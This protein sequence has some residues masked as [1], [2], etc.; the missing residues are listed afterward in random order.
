MKVSL[1]SFFAAIYNTSHSTRGDSIIA[2]L[3]VPC[4]PAQRV[5]VYTSIEAHQY[6]SISIL[7]APIVPDPPP[8]PPGDPSLCSFIVIPSIPATPSTACV[9]PS[10]RTPTATT[11][12]VSEVVPDPT[13]PLCVPDHLR[14]ATCC[15]SPSSSSS[16]VQSQFQ[17]TVRSFSSA[18]YIL[19]PIRFHSSHAHLLIP[20]PDPESN[21][22]APADS[23]EDE[24]ARAA[25]EEDAAAAAVEED[26]EEEEDEDGGDALDEDADAARYDPES[27]RH[28]L[29]VLPPSNDDAHVG[30]AFKSG[31]ST[32]PKTSSALLTLGDSVKTVIAFSN[33]A[34][35]PILV[36]G[37]IGS[38]NNPDNFRI[39]VQN[40]TYGLVNR[41]VEPGHELSFSYSF[42]PNAHLDVRPFQLAITLFYE[43]QSSMGAAL[44]GHSTTFYNATVETQPGS[45]T[46]SNTTFLL[47]FVTLVAAAGGAA[48]IFKN[49][50]GE[51]NE[52]V[53]T[54]T[55]DNSK[56]EWLEEHHNLI[57]TGGGRGKGKAGSAKE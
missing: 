52:T 9:H 13:S 21:S 12:P 7:P 22:P 15:S 47:F 38:L 6:Q 43:T 5:H 36:W 57:K 25:A 41:T 17:Q 3:P 2:L 48:Y 4:H 56:N 23:A 31:M 1:D 14:S 26:A 27:P 55:E 29:S 11:L 16:S 28:P 49:M 53:E 18:P 30:H 37:A 39:H 51:K 45:Q 35:T 42:T 10:P 46:M 19:L 34:K 40:F 8:W 44:R 20:C 32:N 33:Q 50:E 54:G 24:A